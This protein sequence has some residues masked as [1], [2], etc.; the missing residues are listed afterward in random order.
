MRG[1]TCFIF[2]ART[3]PLAPLSLSLSP[4]GLFFNCSAKNPSAHF[5]GLFK[6]AQKSPRLRASSQHTQYKKGERAHKRKH[7]CYNITCMVLP[8]NIA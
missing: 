1:T 8:G 2:S 5:T 7:L 4:L 6:F 3:Q